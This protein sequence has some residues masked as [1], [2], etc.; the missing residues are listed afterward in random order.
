MAFLFS[1]KI[2][3]QAESVGKKEPFQSDYARTKDLQK[4]VKNCLGRSF[5]LKNSI[6]W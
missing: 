3:N 5:S 2:L 6:I 1:S 4:F